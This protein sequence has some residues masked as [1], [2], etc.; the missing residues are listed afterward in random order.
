MAVSIDLKPLND[1]T[2]KQMSYR[3]HDLWIVKIDSIVF[4]PFETESLKHYVGDNEHLFEHAEASLAD[5]SNWK[6]FW[7]STG[8][9]QKK[10]QAV[11]SENYEGPF[12]IM[13][14]GL[15]AGPFSYKEI[16]KKIEM[17]LLVMTDNLSVDNGE[18]WIKIYQVKG[19]DRRSHSPDE[20]PISPYESSFQKAHLKIL[21]K[22]EQSKREAIEG[23]ASVAFEGLQKG[24][25]NPIKMEEMTLKTDIS[26]EITPSLNIIFP[27]IAISLILL[28]SATYVMFSIS[29][30]DNA[31]AD[32]PN[33]EAKTRIKN[34]SAGSYSGNIPTAGQRSPASSEYSE[35]RSS[36]GNEPRYP[37][38]VETHEDHQNDPE[39]DRGPAEAS[40]EPDQPQ[41]HSLVGNEPGDQSLDAAMNNPSPGPVEQPMIE[42]ASDF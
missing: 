42:E 31:I 33:N 1:E 35:Q 25:Q 14:M 2:I 20:L 34:N 6:P 23:L 39:I 16:D 19:L 30:E 21:S 13:E 28:A 9:Q 15:K 24:K 8:F 41:E 12:W 3:S 18:N 37:T 10:L 11:S 38:Q 7:E 27:A 26:P 5:E 32:L 4:G 36:F 17:G 40:V 29:E 22:L